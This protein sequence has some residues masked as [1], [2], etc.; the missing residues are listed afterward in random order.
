MEKL[1]Q[2]IESL[3]FVSDQSIGFALLKESLEN[4]FETKVDTDSIESAIDELIEKYQDEKFAIEIVEINN[5][6][7]FMTKGAYHGIVG[8]YIKIQSSRR[9]STAALETLAIIAYRQPVVKSEMEKIRGVSCD[10]SVQKL[11]EKE[12]V[13]ISGRSEGPGRP[14]EYSTS[15]KFMEYFGL[16]DMSDMPKIKDFNI[17]DSQV[18]EPAPLEEVIAIPSEEIS[19]V[20]EELNE[21]LPPVLGP[22]S[23]EG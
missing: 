9:L 11:L 7:K 5:G 2:Y 4:H 17:P 23:E 8:A 15:D 22:P 13:A 12:L 16:R 3:I 6:F 14:L 1:S 10:Y 20:K 21:E 19:E 18:G